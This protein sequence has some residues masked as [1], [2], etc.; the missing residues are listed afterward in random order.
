MTDVGRQKHTYNATGYTDTEGQWT[1]GRS[2]DNSTF[3]YK[4]YQNEGE[5]KFEFISGNQTHFFA[6]QYS[7]Y[8]C[9]R[10]IELDGWQIY[11][12]T[13]MNPKTN[14]IA[15]LSIE[16]SQD[17]AE[18][19]EV[20][21]FI[22]VKIRT[23]D[24]TIKS[25]DGQELW[26]RYFTSVNLTDYPPPVTVFD[27]ARYSLDNGTAFEVEMSY[28]GYMFMANQTFKLVNITDCRG[29]GDCRDRRSL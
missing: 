9:G 22:D 29:G 2:I 27:S 5:W 23:L 19:F 15:G 20:T 17:S 1:F 12:E 11:M 25:D 13:I 8:E 6:C 28:T 4:F 26:N 10:S 3:I 24:V 16:Y 7:Q 14:D 21:E 18:D